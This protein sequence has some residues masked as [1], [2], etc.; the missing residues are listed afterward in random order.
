M[1]LVVDHRGWAS[2]W[3]IGL[4]I[5]PS[6]A[7]PLRQ[8]NMCI[9]TGGYIHTLVIISAPISHPQRLPPFSWPSTIDVGACWDGEKMRPDIP[10]LRS[11]A[12]V[13]QVR[14]LIERRTSLERTERSRCALPSRGPKPNDPQA[15]H[16]SGPSFTS[17]IGSR[18]L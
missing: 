14:T 2:K 8:L 6:S 10:L 4:V 13:C 9:F 3:S 5:S 7:G 11:A 16:G 15:L 17:Q 1:I 18:F 12:A